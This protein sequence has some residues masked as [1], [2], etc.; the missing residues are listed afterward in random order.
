[1][2]RAG[3]GMIQSLK[4]YVDAGDA[5]ITEFNANKERDL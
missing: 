4:H 1:M 3:I 2:I 5:F